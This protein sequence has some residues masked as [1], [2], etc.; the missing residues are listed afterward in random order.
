MRK[1]NF[2]AALLATFLLALTPLVAQ[3]ETSAGVITLKAPGNK[4]N[5][6]LVTARL[7]QCIAMARSK[8]GVVQ[9]PKGDYLINAGSIT[10]TDQV[11]IQGAGYKLSRFYANSAG[12]VITVDAS[13]SSSTGRGPTI[14]D[15]GIYSERATSATGDIAIKVTNTGSANTAFVHVERVIVEGAFHICV[16]MTNVYFSTVTKSYFGNYRQHAIRIQST[17]TVDAGDH[18]IADNWMQPISSGGGYVA[19][20]SNIAIHQ[21]SGTRIYANT[22]FPG[23]PT[24]IYVHPNATYTTEGFPT[25]MLVISGNQFDS[26]GSGTAVV[27][28]GTWGDGVTGDAEHGNKIFNIQITGNNLS[29][30]ARLVDVQSRFAGVIGVVGNQA[31]GGGGIRVATDATVYGMYVG[32]NF[33]DNRSHSTTVGA[34]GSGFGPSKAVEL[35]G[36]EN[37]IKG[38]GNYWVGYIAAPDLVDSG[39]SGGASFDVTEASTQLA[40]STSK[41]RLPVNAGGFANTWAVA[42]A[43]DTITWAVT[44]DTAIVDGARGEH[45]IHYSGTSVA[46]KF[47]APTGYTLVKRKADTLPTAVDNLL[48]GVP[49][50]VQGSRIFY[51]I[52]S[53]DTIAGLTTEG[54]GGSALMEDSFTSSVGSMHGRT[55]DVTAGPTTWSSTGTWVWTVT[56]SGW[57]APNGEAVAL[58]TYDV[59]TANIQMVCSVK[60]EAADTWGNIQFNR[61]AGGTYWSITWRA[62]DGYFALIDPSGTTVSSTF[63]GAMAADFV[64]TITAKDD[65]VDV[66]IGAT[67][68]FDYNVASRANATEDIIGLANA[69]NG[70]MEVYHITVSAAP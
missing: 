62:S 57:A 22:F 28:D 8:N 49:W 1:I 23:H 64:F 20:G 15:L 55:P 9:V 58:A 50:Y 51:G 36:T 21:A 45:H 63:L 66:L 6:V 27:V 61:S 69:G 59:G 48:V 30:V 12:A 2:I 26:Y 65:D 42:T 7:N 3:V 47:Q 13:L 43:A 39:G 29:N 10:L 67:S 4:T 34:A 40:Y 52:V 68:V 18:V 16:D 54:G 32:A 17:W 37:D 46:P 35:D 11:V 33:F 25:G 31:I 24:G 53:Y 60:V 38:A 5:A 56:A 70:I 14:R 19:T 44:G 41:L